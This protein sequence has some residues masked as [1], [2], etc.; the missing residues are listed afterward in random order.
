MPG[1]VPMLQ[2]VHMSTSS[3]GVPHLLFPFSF[4]LNHLLIKLFMSNSTLVT[5][6]GGM[7]V[8]FLHNLLVHL[9]RHKIKK[10]WTN[11]H[12]PLILPLFGLHNVSLQPT[13]GI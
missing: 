8:K 1:T 13:V 12:V 5:P 2:F 10:V 11:W 7:L 4:K 3:K 9:V 6:M